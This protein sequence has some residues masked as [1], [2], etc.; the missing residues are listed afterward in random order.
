[1]STS[2]TGAEIRRDSGSVALSV[3][4]SLGAVLATVGSLGFISLNSLPPREAYAHPVS[5]VTCALAAIGCLVL[6][7]ALVRWRTT[8][9]AWAVLAAAAGLIF[10]SAS[11]YAQG[12]FTVAAATKTDN[13]LFDQ[14]F[15]GSPWVLGGMVPKSLLCLAGFLAMA[16]VGWRRRSIPRL[17]AVLLGVAAI[18]SIWPPY[19]PGV[20]VASVAIFVIARGPIEVRS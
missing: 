6:S 5:I 14:L 12:T 1:M 8:L 13:A 11:A 16:I 18:L 3:A 9:P 10:A 17:A 19:P 15:F 2:T 20:I 7:L 4:L